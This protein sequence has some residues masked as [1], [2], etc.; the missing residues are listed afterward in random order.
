MYTSVQ[1]ICE[2]VNQYFARDSVTKPNGDDVSMLHN[3]IDLAKSYLLAKSEECRGNNSNQEHSAASTSTSNGKVESMN[4]DNNDTEPCGEYTLL[5]VL[6][7]F[8]DSRRSSRQQW[9]LYVKDYNDVNQA[10]N[11]YYN[12]GQGEKITSIAGDQAIQDIRGV[13][14]PGSQLSNKPG[15]ATLFDTESYK[16]VYL[17]YVN[18]YIVSARQE[19]LAYLEQ[20][21]QNILG[22]RK[23][24]TDDD[25]VD[26]YENEDMDDGDVCKYCL[27]GLDVEG[28]RLFICDACNQCVHQLCETP[29]IQNEEIEIDPWMCRDCTA[30]GRKPIMNTNDKDDNT[31]FT[32]QGSDEPTAKRINLQ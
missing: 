11:V 29:P 3:V 6:M 22:K 30:A 16:P 5:A 21:R 31:Q 24:I 20:E 14:C 23:V 25:Y 32:N 13:A 8:K 12:D 27:I 7:S 17:V 28:N 15:N 1:T 19:A 18:A 10:W 9:R 4:V 2:G 26:D